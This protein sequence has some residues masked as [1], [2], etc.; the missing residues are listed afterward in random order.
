MTH[1]QPPLLSNI[2]SRN[3]RGEGMAFPLLLDNACK[4][5][6]DTLIERLTTLIE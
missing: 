1:D 3:G 6:R 2:G 4:K 5:D